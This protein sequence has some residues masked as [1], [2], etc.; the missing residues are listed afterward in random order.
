MSSVNSF[1]WKRER[2]GGWLIGDFAWR[3]GG[4][5]TRYDD[6]HDVWVSSQVSQDGDGSDTLKRREED[7]HVG[8]VVNK[9]PLQEQWGLVQREDEHL[10][11][12]EEVTVNG[13]R[14]VRK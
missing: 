4:R 3:G 2:S 8:R 7:F 11:S 10:C 6:H 5:Y 13:L 9:P 14:E 12:F 1:G